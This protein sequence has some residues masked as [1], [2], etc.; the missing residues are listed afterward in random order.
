M[1]CTN[2][3]RL[4]FV[5]MHDFPLFLSPYGESTHSI[6]V[7]INDLEL[8]NLPLNLDGVISNF[9]IIFPTQREV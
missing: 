5:V 1:L 9:L 6:N 8:V 2:Q 7:P 3:L 4:D